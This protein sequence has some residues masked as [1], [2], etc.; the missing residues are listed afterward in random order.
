MTETDI[1]RDRPNTETQT[2][3]LTASDTHTFC[4]VLPTIHM[5]PLFSPKLASLKILLRS[6]VWNL[7]ERD[8]NGAFKAGPTSCFQ[9][10]METNERKRGG[11]QELAEK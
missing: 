9:P 3:N 8:G 4:Q 11:L 5:Q 7:G 1:W 2:H 10:G 6:D